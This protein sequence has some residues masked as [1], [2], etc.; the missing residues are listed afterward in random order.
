VKREPNIKKFQ[1]AVRERGSSDKDESIVHTII[2]RGIREGRIGKLDDKISAKLE[3]A[4]KKEA[5]VK[6]EL[7][8]E[9]SVL[10]P[11]VKP[12]ASEVCQFNP[13][14]QKKF[15]FF[16]KLSNHENPVRHLR[17]DKSLFDAFQR[18]KAA[19]VKDVAEDNADI[20]RASYEWCME[21]WLQDMYYKNEENKNLPP[22]E[23]YR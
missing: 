18:M 11:K 4:L 13:Q 16:P 20:Q 17:V 7:D 22:I 12:E 15:F 14:Q 2:R 10:S 9:I 3:S 6:K 8:S 23:E 21:C 1:S 5:S 19:I